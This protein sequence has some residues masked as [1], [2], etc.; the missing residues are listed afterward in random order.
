MNIIFF[1]SESEKHL[2]PLHSYENKIGFFPIAGS[3]FAETV[4]CKIQKNITFATELEIQVRED[5]W[6]SV[7]LLKLISDKKNVLVKNEQGETI[8]R[9]LFSKAKENCKEEIVPVDAKSLIIKY[10]WDFLKVNEEV[11]SELKENKIKGIVRQGVNIDGVVEIGEG[12]VLLPGVYIE[13]NAAIGKN[14]KIGPNCYI[15]GNTHI[16]NGCH[17]GQAVEIKNSIILDKAS[18][19]HLSYVGDSIIAEKTNLGAGTITANL[20]HDGKNH[21]SLVNGKSMDTGRRKLG[22]IVG[23]EVH[24]GINTTLYPGRKLWPH[25]STLPGEIVKTDKKT[26]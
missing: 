20:R 11:V 15:R 17:I 3:I 2:E 8:L 14:C 16:G 22:V 5:F 21:G 6:P 24:T 7:E 26:L 1:K 9:L 10:P 19:G 13:G 18:I 12:T 25:T 4:T 23:E